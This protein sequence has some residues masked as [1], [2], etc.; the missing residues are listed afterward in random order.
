MKKMTRRLIGIAIGLVLGWY[1]AGHMTGWANTQDAPIRPGHASSSSH[2]EDLP[3]PSHG[4]D[5]S[6]AGHELTAAAKL[7]PQPQHTRW[8][9]G[10]LTAV[11]GLFAGAILLGIPAMKR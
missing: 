1:A 3:T 5:R 6:A 4:S 10:V 2:H 9:S 7:K 11:G 8:Y